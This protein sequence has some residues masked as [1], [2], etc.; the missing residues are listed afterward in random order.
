MNSIVAA[1]PGILRAVS[2]MRTV[3]RLDPVTDG[4]ARVDT[5]VNILEIK[6]AAICMYEGGPKSLVTL[7]VLPQ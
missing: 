2:R 5:V 3:I 1:S 6:L 4:I 7:T